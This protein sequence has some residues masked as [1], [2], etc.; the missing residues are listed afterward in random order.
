MKKSKFTDAQIGFVLPPT[1]PRGGPAELR[2]MS[3]HR[4][5]TPARSV[6]MPGFV[7]G[8]GICPH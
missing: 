8:F 3:G 7:F 6:M 1:S 4:C 2:A 5:A